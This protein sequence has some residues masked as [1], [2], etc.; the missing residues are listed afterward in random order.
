M[1]HIG[2]DAKNRMTMYEEAAKAAESEFKNVEKEKVKGW[3]M[4]LLKSIEEKS[5]QKERIE[6]EIRILRKD[7]EELKE[8]KLEKIK[9]R[10][11]KST[12][13]KEI[14]PIGLQDIIYKFLAPSSPMYLL[15]PQW[16]VESTSGTYTVNC[17]NLINGNWTKI[18]Y[19]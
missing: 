19:I 17:E 14:S 18:Y 10:Q 3:V 8:G 11:E 2:G 6:E 7:L 16:W 4:A 9:E 1:S 15:S 13:A 12:L 5:K